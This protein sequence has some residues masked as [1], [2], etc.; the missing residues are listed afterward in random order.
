[1]GSAVSALTGGLLGGKPKKAPTTIIRQTAP[2][3]TKT[4]PNKSEGVA[5]ARRRRLALS[6]RTGRSALRI[7]LAQGSNKGTTRTGLSIQ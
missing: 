2:Q 4:D 6:R 3:N 7:D 5:D 1:M